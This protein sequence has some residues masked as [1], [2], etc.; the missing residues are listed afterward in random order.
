MSQRRQISVADTESVPAAHRTRIRRLLLRWYD[1]H[2]RDLPWRRRAGDPFAQWVAEIML[3]QTRVETVIPYYDRFMRRFPDIETLAGASDSSV[4]KH[5]E[6]LGYYRR[7]DNLRRAVRLLCDRCEPVPQC[8]DELRRLPG[9]GMYTAAAIAS[10]AFGECV[11]AVDGN[12]ARVIARLFGVQEDILKRDGKKIVDRLA[13]DLIP[14][15]RPGDFN[16]AWMELGSMVCTPRSPDCQRCPLRDVCQAFDQGNTH[17]LPIRGADRRLA[18][19]EV[20]TAVA[21]LIGKSKMLVRHRPPGGLWSGLWEFPGIELNGQAEPSRRLRGFL[22]RCGLAILEPLRNT[23]IVRHQLTH[24]TMVF[25]TYVARV[26]CGNQI[27]IGGAASRWVSRSAFLRLAISRA[28]RK[29]F[30]V[31]R[32][33]VDKRIGHYSA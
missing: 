24:R 11:A 4:L 7:I 3:Q 1:H 25:H 32:E 16:Q 18:P 6:G 5:W 28:H 27:D 20:R 22:E 12:A 30:D 19:R 2:K 26:E 13:G 14:P 8:V 21:I 9:V 31:A 33:Q 23:G 17:T 29:I 15:K 10:I